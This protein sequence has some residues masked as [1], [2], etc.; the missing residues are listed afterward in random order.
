MHYRSE[1][2]PYDNCY[3]VTAATKYRKSEFTEPIRDY[4]AHHIREKA[5]S[6]DLKMYAVAIAAC[7]SDCRKNNNYC[8]YGN[9]QQRSGNGGELQ[10]LSLFQLILPEGISLDTR[11]SFFCI[12]DIS[13]HRYLRTAKS[14]RL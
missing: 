9:E 1:H 14:G 8:F 3:H 10:G 12:V 6:L 2:P 7:D 13:A 4:L 11:N 5:A